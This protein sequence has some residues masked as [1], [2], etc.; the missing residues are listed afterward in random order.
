MHAHTQVIAVTYR[1][2]VERG[3]NI[4][5]RILGFGRQFLGQ[6]KITQLN[7]SVLIKE[8]IS[9][10]QVTVQHRLHWLAGPG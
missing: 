6:P 7:V 8:D 1:R 9:G 4:G 5:V 2:H 10:L 3:A